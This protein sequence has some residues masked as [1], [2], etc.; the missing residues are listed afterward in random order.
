MI[1]RHESDGSLVM[2]TQNDHAVI[3]GFCAAH[4]GNDRFERPDPF[5]STMRATLLHD[6]VWL[7]EESSPCFD[8]STGQTPNFLAVPFNTQEEEYRSTIDWI[9]RTDPYA[10]WLVSRHRTGIWKSRYG[11]MKQPHY[12]NRNLNTD[13]EDVVARNHAEQDAAAAT[14]DRQKLTINYIL[15]Q[16]WDLLSLYV[17]CNEHLKELSIE[18]VPTS[19]TGEHSVCIRLAPVAPMRIKVDPYPFD[20]PSLEVTMVYRR[21]A[22]QVFEDE[23]AFQ[24]EYFEAP[25]KLA[26]FTFFGPETATST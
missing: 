19:Y 23:S 15:L 5:L 8:A 22:R 16:V 20:R 12:P 1:V 4:W 11:L 7:R 3:A 17:C 10:G 18:P 6:L 26:K 14:L 13:I 24:R 21:L 25:Q 9:N 2:I